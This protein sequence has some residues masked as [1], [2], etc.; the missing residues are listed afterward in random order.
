VSLIAVLNG[1]V[2][3]LKSGGRWADCPADYAPKNTIYNRSVRWAERGIWKDIFAA[4]AGRDEDADARHQRKDKRC[5]G[6]RADPCFG[7][8]AHLR[9]P[10]TFML[11]RYNDFCSIQA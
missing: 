3:V 9:P 7:L 4:L 11:A 8:I 5:R 10:S 1:I 2:H 6:H